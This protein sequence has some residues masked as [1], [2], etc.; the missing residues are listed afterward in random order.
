MFRIQI[1]NLEGEVLREVLLSSGHSSSRAGV[2]LLD[3]L[4]QDGYPAR[5]GCR[6]GV[7]GTCRCNV[8]RGRE[9]ID[10]ESLQ[11]PA[12]RF[13]RPHQILPCIATLKNATEVSKCEGLIELRLPAGRGPSE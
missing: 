12:Y 6:G 2:S 11:R 5:H 1:L 13:L 10:S 8:V 7:C 4:L 3:I 9:H